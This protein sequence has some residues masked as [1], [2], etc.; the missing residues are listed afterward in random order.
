MMT[1]LVDL[2]LNEVEDIMFFDNVPNDDGQTD[3]TMCLVGMFLANKP[4][5]KPHREVAIKEVDKG[6][7]VF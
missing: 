7:H 3:P 5:K 4:I 2:N 6:V 1:S